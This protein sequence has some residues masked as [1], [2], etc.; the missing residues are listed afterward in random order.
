M[1]VHEFIRNIARCHKFWLLSKEEAN[2]SNKV[3]FE[4][5]GCQS[6]DK[7][8][9]VEKRLHYKKNRSKNKVKLN[10]NKLHFNNSLVEQ[11]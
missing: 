1:H 6:Q 11:L 8:Y 2:A 3:R 7:V 10:G 9:R 5:V 4:P